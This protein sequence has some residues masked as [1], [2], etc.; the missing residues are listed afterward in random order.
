MFLKTNSQKSSCFGSILDLTG[1][2]ACVYASLFTQ[3]IN[4][5]DSLS[6]TSKT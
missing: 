5:D 2:C 3:M 4:Q 1:V 6:G